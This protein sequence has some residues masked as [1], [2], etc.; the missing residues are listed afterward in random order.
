MIKYAVYYL[1]NC[2]NPVK[3]PDNIRLEHGQM[4]LVRT[5]KGEE[6]LKVTLVNDE[7]KAMGK[8]RAQT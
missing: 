7:I 3:V 6:A 2:F 1:K 5:E 4:I 8:I